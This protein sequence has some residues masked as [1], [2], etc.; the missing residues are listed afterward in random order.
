MSLSSTGHLLEGFLIRSD[1]ALDKPDWYIT[2]LDESGMMTSGLL[3]KVASSL[4]Y[5]F[6]LWL[7]QSERKGNLLDYKDGLGE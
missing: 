6:T 3:T 4:M 2:V 7:Y 1:A 5:Q